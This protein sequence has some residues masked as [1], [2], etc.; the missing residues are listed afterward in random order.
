MTDGTRLTLFAVVAGIVS[1]VALGCVL[2]A[3]NRATARS[4]AT[5]TLPLAAADAIDQ[6]PRVVF[7]NTEIGSAYGLVAMVALDDPGGPRAVTEVA[8]DRVDARAE[9]TTCLRTDRGIVTTFEAVHLD[10][11]WAETGSW[12]LPGIPSRTRLSPDGALVATTSFVGGHS[13]QETG[14]STATEI[15]RVGGRSYGNLERFSLKIDGERVSPDDRNVWGVTFGA[16]DDTFYATVDTAGRTRLVRGDLSARSL[17]SLDVD[18]ECPSLSPDG[19]RIAFKRA[20]TDEDSGWQ[21]V[22]RELA[23]GQETVLAGETRSVDDQVAWLGDSL[24]YG[25]PR[26][27]QPGVSDV[28]R[29]D[30]SPQAR[31][32]LFVEQ[33]WSPSVVTEPAS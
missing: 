26:R 30:V 12:P 33:A 7:R 24:L 23:S 15:R 4:E 9:A 29:I 6:E 21:L 13:Y 31:P 3:L 18:A 17:T 22:V 32:A 14:F 11:D 20:R 8:C 16:D 10:A 27:S 2:I 25:M 28:W 1:L 19:S 5:P